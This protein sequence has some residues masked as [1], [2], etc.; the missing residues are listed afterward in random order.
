VELD[1]KALTF[2]AN[3]IEHWMNWHR[4]QLQRVDLTDDE[5]SDLTNDLYYLRSLLADVQETRRR[6]SGLNDRDWEALRRRERGD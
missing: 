1:Y 5:H 3:A 2:I 4:E 6:S